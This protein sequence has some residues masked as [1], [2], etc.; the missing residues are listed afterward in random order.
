MVGHVDGLDAARARRRPARALAQNVRRATAHEVVGRLQGLL[1]GVGR[2]RA[3]LLRERADDGE[4]RVVHLVLQRARQGRDERTRVVCVGRHLRE[5]VRGC[6]A[7]DNVVGLQ[8]FARERGEVCRL[9]R[10]QRAQEVGH[11][12]RGRVLTLYERAQSDLRIG[13]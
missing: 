11:G 10:L 12:E 5:Y 8:L 3:L 1:Q 7:H 9:E 13:L 6:R 4:R 2:L